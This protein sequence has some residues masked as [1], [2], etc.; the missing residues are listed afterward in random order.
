[1]INRVIDAFKAY[2]EENQRGFMCAWV[3][4]MKDL[5]QGKY[6]EGVGTWRDIWAVNYPD[7]PIPDSFPNGWIPYGW[8]F[9]NMMRGVKT[10][11]GEK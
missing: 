1:M 6:I 2:N 5:R 11:K 7:K 3:I 4:M 8:S 9:A 10:G